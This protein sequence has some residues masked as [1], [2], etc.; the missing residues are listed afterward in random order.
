MLILTLWSAYLSNKINC[1][2]TFCLVKSCTQDA[3]ANAG[4]LS[5]LPHECSLSLTSVVHHHWKK[6]NITP[7]AL[8]LDTSIFPLFAWIWR[9]MLNILR[10]VIV[11]RDFA[12]VCFLDL[13]FFTRPKRLWTGELKVV[14]KFSNI[15]LLSRNFNLFCNNSISFKLVSYSYLDF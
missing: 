13:T 2:E 15:W 7:V 6:N 1:Y 10:I 8:E 14:W 9:Q 12:Q 11:T 4:K 3:A 5:I